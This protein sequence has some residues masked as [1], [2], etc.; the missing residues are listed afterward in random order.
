M[1]APGGYAAPPPPAA[2]MGIEENL[3]AALCYIP[4]VGLIFLLIDPYKQNR[5]VRFNAW[6][7]LMYCVAF[8][9]LR[10]GLT[11]VWGILRMGLPYSMYGLWAML[12]GLVS[13]A[14]VGGLIFMAV[15][16]YQRSPL[17]LPVI[18]PLAQKQAG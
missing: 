6:Q 17:V 7:S 8:F 11:I 16:A 10:I 15:K 4:I 1:A 18:G 12:M 13:L 9:V 14:Y 5:N 3:A 2:A